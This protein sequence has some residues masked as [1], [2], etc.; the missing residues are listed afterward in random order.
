MVPVRIWLLTAVLLM[1]SLAQ[2]CLAAGVQKPN[3][4]DD[5][6]WASLQKA[7]MRS[8]VRE[9]RL[10]G[11]GSAPNAD[12]AADDNFGHA[13]ALSGDTAA[14]GV[15][16]D[17]IGNQTDQGSVYVYR[18]LG[19]AGWALQAKLVAADGAA[20][21][22]FGESIAL[23]GNLLL[24]GASIADGDQVNQGSAY[25][26]ALGGNGWQLQKKLQA[27]DG[28]SNDYFGRSVAISGDTV[29]IGAAGD[30]IGSQPDRGSA[31]VY[32]RAGANWFEQ[33]KLVADD[34]TTADGFGNA[35]AA[36]GDTLFVG[37]ER[38]DVAGRLDQG[39]VYAFH[40]T[41]SIWTQQL[42]LS[43]GDGAAL[44][45][46]GFSIA[47][48]AD[49]A[50]IGAPGQLAGRGGA[51]I[52]VRNGG[53]WAYQAKL[54][55]QDGK[56]SDYFGRAVAIHD[57]TVIVGAPGAGVTFRSS[58][59]GAAYVY[60]RTG[61][62][63]DRQAKLAA[64]N[65]SQQDAFGSAVALFA[66]TA[67][68]A[69]VWD[70]VRDNVDQGSTYVHVRNGASWTQ[71]TQIAS[72]NGEK[73]ESFGNSISISGD[74]ALI[75]EYMGDVGANR[76]QG[77][78]FV[79]VRAKAGWELQATLLAGDGGVDEYFGVSVALSGDLALVGSYA[80][81]GANR[82]QGAVYVY[83]RSGSTWTQH[84]KLV[85]SDG[86]GSD[87]FGVSLALSG[88]TALVGATQHGTSVG[89]RT[90]A[91]YVYVLEETQWRQQAKLLAGDGRADDGFGFPIVFDGHTALIGAFRADLA[92][93]ADQGSAYVFTRK[94]TS[95]AQQA[96]LVASDGARGDNFA[97]GLSLDGDVAAIGALSDDVG[98]NID[99]G[100]AYV[101]TRSG[102]VWTQQSQLFAGD[103]AAS[104]NF[105]SA[106]MINAD[107]LLIGAYRDD[108]GA[109]D[110]GS[111]YEFARAQAGWSL[112]TKWVLNDACAGDLFGFPIIAQGDNVFVGAIGSAGPAPFGNRQ[113]GSVYVFSCFDCLFQSGFETP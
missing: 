24:I 68:I 57:N 52:F 78:V 84:S 37:A 22:R 102:S 17:D 53:S 28:A 96:K 109:I 113:E 104:D 65:R 66:E 101:F 85:A 75:G 74:T 80:D 54:V 60:A 94:G 56:S 64:S 16:Q 63:W 8:V 62:N 45:L 103:G 15:P 30:D 92:S 40:R 4:L 76:D 23:E 39:S 112:R 77:R 49:T 82:S 83:S 27:N 9:A 97:Y 2:V 81:S 44:D 7:F 35:L 6:S 110:Q 31:Y 26:Y 21:D 93:N 12:G 14:I 95:W 87:L 69:A 89:V 88:S 34:G 73:N 51:Y 100:S 41:G 46:F 91:V 70:D 55:A 19:A 61:T 13:I 48:S 107:T 79:F 86:A 67:V 29:I 90:G 105:G 5:A 111:V 18:N 98:A 10:S 1:L 106:V 11:S 59:E 25:L 50:I 47:I 71:Q 99:Q 3:E 33:A 58:D 32:R 72:S 36:S 43:S 42:R 38:D 108:A 20:A